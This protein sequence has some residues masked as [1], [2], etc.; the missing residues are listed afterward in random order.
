[1]NKSWCHTDV[2]IVFSN[3]FLITCS[4][5]FWSIYDLGKMFLMLCGWCLWFMKKTMI[6]IYLFLKIVYNQMIWILYKL[7]EELWWHD[8][9]RL[10]T[11]KWK[12]EIDAHGF[13]NVLLMIYDSQRRPY[14]WLWQRRSMD[15]NTQDSKMIT[16]R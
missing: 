11:I 6:H 12:D 1:M 5:N 7:N 15:Q 16:K 8:L 14:D 3:R 9:M 2:M 13:L 10:K 4:K